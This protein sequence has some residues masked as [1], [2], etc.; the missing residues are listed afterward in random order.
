LTI[1][2][3]LTGKPEQDMAAVVCKNFH[4]QLFGFEMGGMNQGAQQFSGFK[5]S[6]HGS[7]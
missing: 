6:R 2:G 3:V 4:W 5:R 7:C 1:Q